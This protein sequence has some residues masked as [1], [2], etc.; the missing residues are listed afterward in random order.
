M[1]KVEGVVEMAQSNMYIGSAYS[2]LHFPDGR[3]I[4]VLSVPFL[5][6]AISRVLDTAM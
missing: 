3:R 2:N 6:C 4:R 5:I 1:Y